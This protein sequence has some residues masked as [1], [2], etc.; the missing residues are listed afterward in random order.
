MGRDKYL[1]Y[2]QGDFRGGINE[3][4]TN[5]QPNQVFDAR[6]VWAPRGLLEQ[7]PGYVG[8]TAYG[9]LQGGGTTIFSARTEVVAAGADDGTFTSP[10]G[11]GLL[12][13]AG[14]VGRA[15]DGGAR[16]R[17]YIGHSAT[18]PG[19]I[20]TITTQN[21]AATGFKAEYWN[22]S[23]W[24]Y[25]LV[26][27]MTSAGVNLTT[28]F[29]GANASTF[30]WAVPKDWTL[31]TV[32]STSAYWIRFELLEENI[33][34]GTEIDVDVST[35][36]KKAFTYASSFFVAQ[37]PGIKRYI[38]SIAG[39]K[40]LQSTS[41]ILSSDKVSITSQSILTY[42]VAE[43]ASF[44]VIPQ[45]GEVYIAQN[46]FITVSKA[47]PTSTDLSETVVET[48]PVW[49]GTVQ[50]IKSTYH[51]DFVPQAAEFPRANY[52]EFFDGQLFAAGIL[53]AS[54]RI[55]WSAPQPA[56]K[57]WPLESYE[58]IMENDN[59]PITGMRAFG[60]HLAVFKQDSIWRMLHTGQSSV[61]GD[62][63]TYVP[64]K[65][66]PGSGVGCVSNSSIVEINGMLVFLAEDGIYSFNGSEISKLSSAIDDTIR[67]ITPGLRKWSAACH[68]RKFNCYLLAVS[69]DGA[70]NNNTVLVYDYKN[71]SWWIWDDI[72][73]VTWI[74]DEGEY[75]EQTIYFGDFT[76]R[77][78]QLGVGD[79]D[80]GGTITSYVI[81]HRVGA[82]V[83]DNRITK[84]LR[85]VSV[86]AENI[87]ISALTVTNNADDN[88]TAVST[89][90]D[91]T[92]ANDPIGLDSFVMDT[93]KVSAQ[94]QRNISI[95]FRS[96]GN[97]FQTKITNT[98]KN[99]RLK[100]W[101]V[102]HGFY[103]LGRR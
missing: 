103:P 20:I 35:T 31:K 29:M 38:Q 26:Q 2:R 19:F 52:V 50:G 101:N 77:V 34:A 56:Y 30:I 25:L 74:V 64:T 66:A 32:D 27:A 55:Q 94:K 47:Q 82:G 75:D 86:H 5:A 4:Q 10:D 61:Q 87:D 54:Y 88:D 65:M 62:L 60:E 80:H 37:F 69:L 102:A 79:T 33:S 45:F 84:E 22:G 63:N 68:W 46:N 16:G 100:L 8:V 81:F 17:V 73:V 13:L 59:S 23:A 14:L 1:Y 9:L 44:A 58:E 39:G 40:V 89:T 7:R 15:T 41:S 6:N 43:L 97:W 91:F 92:D 99:V 18:W 71:G 83:E 57:V 12:S 28:P 95:P 96:V 53:G 11:T 76:D 3:F 90:A 85:E 42:S 93:T 51:P 24:M 98:T 70:A 49:V 72:E 36:Q 48:D 78:F 67:K 21:T